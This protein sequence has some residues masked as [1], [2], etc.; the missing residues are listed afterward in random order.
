MSNTHNHSHNHSEGN[1]KIAF[2]LN[3]GFT[4]VEIIGGLYTNSLAIL[5]DALHDLGDSLSL[6]LSWYFQRLSKKGSTKKFSYGYKRFSLL[7]AIINS[8]VLVVGSIFILSK[9]IPELFNPEETNAQG[10]LYLAI[11]GVVVNGAAVFKLRKGKSL[12]EKVVSLHLLEDV[13]G[14]VAVLI[15]SIVMIYFD[16]PFVD[17]LLSILI[18][19]FV[20]YNVYRNK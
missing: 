13:L 18:S 7:G 12:N 5:S 10:M 19:I 2:F 4:I 17:P 9:A 20:L 8:I 3:L 11:L 6:G 14:W 15:G 16:L 1:I